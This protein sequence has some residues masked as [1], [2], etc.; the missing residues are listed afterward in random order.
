[1]YIRTR[2]GQERVKW[3]KPS[4][5]KLLLLDPKVK[6]DREAFEIFSSLLFL[7]LFLSLIDRHWK[8]LENCLLHAFLPSSSLPSKTTSQFHP[9]TR[10][11]CSL[12]ARRLLSRR[13]EMY[14]CL[15]GSSLQSVYKG[16]SLRDNQRPQ[17][18]TVCQNSR[19]SR[20]QEA[21]FSHRRI[22]I[23]VFLTILFER[24]DFS[25]GFPEVN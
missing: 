5:S 24:W 2:T 13:V 9:R 12:F 17:E 18:A 14:R 15:N 11:R 25:L 21:R 7:F 22:C 3:G 20:A 6:R 1:M 23:L 4:L 8:N 10:G 16:E 19:C